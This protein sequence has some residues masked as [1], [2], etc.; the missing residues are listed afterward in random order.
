MKIFE[1]D[2]I[3]KIKMISNI[4][5]LINSNNLL[6][7]IPTFD[8]DNFKSGKNAELQILYDIN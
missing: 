6:E 3:D 7:H 1:N 8:K 4:K 5:N 2:E